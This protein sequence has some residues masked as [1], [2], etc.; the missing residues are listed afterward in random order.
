MP[1][2]CIDIARR[3]SLIAVCLTTIAPAIALDLDR[4]LRESQ[5][6]VGHEVGDYRFTDRDGT[7]VRWSDYRGKPLLVSLIY[8]GC[9]QVCPTTTKFLGKAVQEGQDALGRDAFAVVT[10][11]FNL[12]FDNPQ[13]MNIFAKQQGINLPH[14][15]Y[16]SPDAESVEG[17]MRDLGFSH[18]ANASGFDHLVG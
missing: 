8:T 5:A 15:N 1:R 6:G 17:L 7:R 2:Y 9:S 14:W 18:S 10:I 3:L 16:L 4:A 11:G 13:A 12:P